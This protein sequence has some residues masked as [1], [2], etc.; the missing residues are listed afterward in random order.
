MPELS[1]RPA[2]DAD[3]AFCESLSRANMAAYHSARG[4]AWDQH[5]FL[6]NW[7]LFENF[8]VLADG[9]VAGLLRWLVVDGAL[10]IR[11]LQLLPAQRGR[12][13][14]AWAMGR[15]RSEALARGI[16]SLRLRVFGENPA[17]R[18]Y[19]RL[20]FEV[21]AVDGDGKVHMSCR[22]PMTG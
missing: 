3:I 18:L 2:S 22:L 5:R 8:M 10:E 6:A 9:E 1:L 16:G 11:D 13:V 7:G 14:G 19:R 21:D 17:M 20:G 12:G 4:I 15:A